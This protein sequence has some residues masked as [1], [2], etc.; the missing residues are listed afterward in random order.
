M[1]SKV[2]AA[3]AQ[4]FEPLSLAGA[5]T[6]GS[7][8][9]ARDRSDGRI[10][11]L[12]VAHPDPDDPARPGRLFRQEFE[13]LSIVH[14]RGIVAVEECGEADGVPFLVMEF[15]EGED[16]RRRVERGALP[17][18]DALVVAYRLAEA[19]AHYDAMGLTHGDLKPQN[20]LVGPRGAVKLCDLG[21]AERAFLYQ[22]AAGGP[23][24]AGTPLYTSPEVIR[25]SAEVDIRADLYSFGATLHHLLAGR[26]P[27]GGASVEEIY[28]AHLSTPVPE[29]PAVSEGT[30]AILARLLAKSAAERYRHPFQVVEDLRS[31]IEGRAPE[32][33]LRAPDAETGPG[34]RRGRTLRRPRAWVPASFAVA[35]AVA[36]WVALDRGDGEP[37]PESPAAPVA[38]V[39]PLPASD[40]RAALGASDGGEA[41][42]APSGSAGAASAEDP[43][44]IAARDA[45]PPAAAGT[46]ERTGRA[47]IEPI[48]GATPAAPSAAEAV[49]AGAAAAEIGAEPPVPGTP[50]GAEEESASGREAR[51]ARE[52]AR[53]EEIDPYVFAALSSVP[54][55]P[56]S[57]ILASDLSE[58]LASDWVIGEGWRREAAAI[59]RD[60]D[61]DAVHG[62]RSRIELHPGRWSI[63]L[64]LRSGAEAPS[65]EIRAG[66]A[67]AR[68]ALASRAAEI[69]AA[70]ADGVES[71]IA[72][73]SSAAAIDLPA[74]SPFRVRFARE[75]DR[76][77]ISGGT[78]EPL[79]EWVAASAP[80]EGGSFS[81]ELRAE[82]AGIELLGSRIEGE[83]SDLWPALERVRR[84][85]EDRLFAAI[86]GGDWATAL[87]PGASRA[88]GR[89]EEIELE[90]DFEDTDWRED[91]TCSA[92]GPGGCGG[93]GGNLVIIAGAVSGDPAEPWAFPFAARQ[94]P[95]RFRT[96]SV[97]E[98]RVSG[99]H[100]GDAVGHYVRADPRP[101]AFTWDRA[102]FAWLS[103]ELPS[104]PTQLAR[105]PKGELARSEFDLGGASRVRKVEHR[106]RI[107]GGELRIAVQVDGRAVLEA[108]AGDE[109][110]RPAPAA[111]ASASPGRSG[112]IGLA[113]IGGSA[114]FDDVRLVATLDTAWRDEE[115]ERV[116]DRARRARAFERAEGYRPGL[117][118]ALVSWERAGPWMLG[119]KGNGVAFVPESPSRGSAAGEQAARD[120]PPVAAITLLAW[121]EIRRQWPARA[122]EADIRLEKGKERAGF[123]LARRG[124]GEAWLFVGSLGESGFGVARVAGIYDATDGGDPLADVIARAAAGTPPAG[125]RTARWRLEEERDRVRLSIDGK[126]VIDFEIPEP[127]REVGAAGFAAPRGAPPFTIRDVRILPVES[128]QPA[129]VGG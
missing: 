1:E 60:V 112:P 23:R 70:G 47:A 99:L 8:W 37:L 87:F 120:D 20:V 61:G 32:H 29:I 39:E 96:V 82:R 30:R 107:Q 6:T 11:A 92:A 38:A 51:E 22:K 117:G 35:G 109:L 63:E 62:L 127:F 17:E 3:L 41:G 98:Y 123:A 4:R 71:T 122:L 73:T 77:R 34:L 83:V 58:G 113:I 64:H 15:I 119:E 86:D 55:D 97:F 31:V 43:A 53:L 40:D 45:A 129:S 24:R 115:F 5:G 108:T 88:R 9:R 28:R 90:Y 48:V 36:L 56:L 103:C 33:A 125:S 75:G 104:L 74:G 78:V 101:G 116:A 13:T 81:P 85:R 19:I 57:V 91:W 126:T 111:G 18:R 93:T 65:F 114:V 59:R 95:G 27:F 7:V 25:R 72:R 118:P 16:L 124:S 66:G 94:L 84:E 52:A 76:L 42:P 110:P 79:A 50:S 69:R 10:V 21:V 100:T 68:I 80:A 106:E 44:S 12:K 105:G 54:G 102:L 46:E 14:H 49:S 121:P 26:P 67:I 89:G 2:P 128:A